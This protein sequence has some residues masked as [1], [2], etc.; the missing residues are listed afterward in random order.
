MLVDAD[1]LATYMDIGRFSNRQEDNATLIIAGVQSEIETYLR[2]PIEPVEYT[3]IYR[4]PE[5]Y[6][7]VSATAYFYDR[8][9]DSTVDTIER[10][11]QPPY[12]IHL[13]YSPVVSV[14][15]VRRRG[16]SEN[17]WTT[18][19]EGPHFSSSKWGLDMFSVVSYDD[20]EVTY[21][22]GLDGNEIPYLKLLV[23][24]VASREM[25]NLTDD[26]VGLKQMD[27]REVAVREVGLSEA[28]KAVLKRW[29]RRQI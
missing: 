25:Q 23:L 15:L 14:D 24:R 1:D 12:V 2:R 5:D 4:I 13:N 10:V 21:T 9:L 17:S 6:L 27:T 22:A 16:L 29:R 7:N 11:V 18:L 19:E 3:E 26:V 8:T 20:I 28:D